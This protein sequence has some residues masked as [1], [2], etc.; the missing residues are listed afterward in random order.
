LIPAA[1]KDMSYFF[2]VLFIIN[3]AFTFGYLKTVDPCA[4]MPNDEKC[5]DLS[6]LNLAITTQVSSWIFL[7]GDF[8]GI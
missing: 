3:Q 1:L 8:S 5:D 6:E 4:S 7:Y 2:I